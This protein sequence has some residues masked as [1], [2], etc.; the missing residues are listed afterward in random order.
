L[1]FQYDLKP[2]KIGTH[3]LLGKLTLYFTV[4]SSEIYEKRTVVSAEYMNRLEKRSKK[5]MAGY[6]DNFHCR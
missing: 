4:L 3:T 1:K 2:L 6:S 5:S